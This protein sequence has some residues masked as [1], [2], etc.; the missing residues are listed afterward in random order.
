MKPFGTSEIKGC[1]DKSR[2]DGAQQIVNAH[3]EN[4]QVELPLSSRLLSVT[5]VHVDTLG[6][7][8]RLLNGSPLFVGKG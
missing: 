3:N 4:V 1:G 2:R 7:G 6:G 8:V 5:V